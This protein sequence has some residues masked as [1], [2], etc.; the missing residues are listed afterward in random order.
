[1]AVEI[2]EL[3]GDAAFGGAGGRGGEGLGG[4]GEAG[5]AFIRVGFAG[6]LG[7][8]GAAAAAFAPSGG[9]VAAVVDFAAGP[10][11]GAVAGGAGGEVALSGVGLDDGD[12]DVENGGGLLGG[13]QVLGVLAVGQG[14]GVPAFQVGVGRGEVVEVVSAFGGRSGT[15]SRKAACL[16]VPGERGYRCGRE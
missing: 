7:F 14:G 5:V 10:E 12:V 11:A 8:A 6:A 15:C 13:Q 3:G 2:C 9:V 16:S 4:D 1:M